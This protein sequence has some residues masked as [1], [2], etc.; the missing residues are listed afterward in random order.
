MFNRPNRNDINDNAQDIRHDVSQLADT[1][2]EV[3]K[4]W[5]TDAKDE[6]DA[7]KRKAQSL[8]RETRARM[9]GRS[10]A[11]QAACDA[12]SCANTFM[13]DKPLCALGTV[14]AVGI[15]VG[16]LLSLRK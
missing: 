10:R 11:T 14:A 2:E 9:N 4:S 5:G 13:R 6:A 1:L 12:V 7:A 16:A 3:L 15:F 8:L